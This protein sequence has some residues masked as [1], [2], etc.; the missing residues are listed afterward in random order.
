MAELKEHAWL[1]ALL[2]LLLV[3]KFIMKYVMD[4]TIEFIRD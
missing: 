4:N 2:T 3:A 1:L